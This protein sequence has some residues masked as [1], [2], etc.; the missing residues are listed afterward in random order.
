MIASRASGLPSTEVHS[1]ASGMAAAYSPP[2]DTGGFS[3]CTTDDE[4]LLP[5]LTATVSFVLR[6]HPRLPNFDFV[7]AGINAGQCLPVGV[8]DEIAARYRMAARF[9]WRRSGSRAEPIGL[10]RPVNHDGERRPRTTEGGMGTGRDDDSLTMP[11]TCALRA[12]RR[13]SSAVSTF[14]CRARTEG[15]PCFFTFRSW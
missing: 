7:V 6:Q 4:I 2:P 13:A 15:S 11:P 5:R 8:A 12:I 10:C 14:A 3:D 9:C 1:G